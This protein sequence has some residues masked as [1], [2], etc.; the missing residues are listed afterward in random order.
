MLTNC[1]ADLSDKLCEEQCEDFNVVQRLAKV[2]FWSLDLCDNRLTWSA[3]IFHLFELNRDT[4]SPSY[5]AFLEVIHPDDRERVNSAYYD[6]LASRLPYEITHRLRMPD[7]RIKYVHEACETIYDEEGRPLLSRGTVQDVTSQKITEKSLNLFATVFR[8]SASAILITD[9]ENHIIACNPALTTLTGYSEYE[10]IGHDPKLL[11]AGQ[12]PAET[13]QQMWSVLRQRGHWDGELFDRRKDGTI[14]PKW[15]SISVVSDREGRVS[16]YIAS[17]TDISDRK[18]T[19]QRIS[20]LAHHDPLTGLTNRYSLTERLVQGIF[21]AERSVQRLAVLFIDLDRFKLINDTLGHDVGDKVLIEVGYRLQKSVR[22]SDIVARLGGD[23]F[24]VV[25]TGLNPGE[26]H[27]IAN[28][29]RQILSQLGQN[30]QIGEHTLSSTPSIGISLYPEDGHDPTTLMKC[31]DTAMYHAKE[32]GRNNYQF[33]T[34]SMNDAT[35]ERMVMEN[36]LRQALTLRQFELYYQPKVIAESGE[37]CGAEGLIRWQ[38]PERGMVSPDQFIPLAEEIGLINPLGLWVFREACRER[39]L[40][41][42]LTTAPLRL[43]VNLSAVQLQDE[44]LAGKFAAIMDQYAIGPDEMEI[45]VTESVAMNKPREAIS[46][47]EALRNLGLEL[48]IDDFGTGYSSLAY[49]KL[50]PIQ[51][52]KLDRTFVKEIEGGV[53]DRAICSATI[54]LAHKLDLKVVAEGVE[55]PCQRDFLRR[56]GCD[57]FQGYL[58]SRPVSAVVM[59]EKINQQG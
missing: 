11:S 42:K 44:G 49:L 39:A 10:L 28:L 22:D 31:A 5:Q 2:G 12:T 46:R 57:Q 54:S 40:W 55:T 4:F 13:Y 43:S 35:Q 45:E 52:L 36:D 30:F 20:Y 1:S 8:H 59:R 51:T 33:F 41:R 56:E 3:E 23:E 15:T 18:A 38:H 47:L 26:T 27:V 25:L 53:D 24:V 16:N 29:A 50:L 9:S 58:F 7:G 32:Q 37:I 19:E 17:F 6:S 21:Q 34:A 14:Y 48:S